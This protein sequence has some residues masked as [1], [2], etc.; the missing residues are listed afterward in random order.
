MFWYV[1]AGIVTVGLLIYAILAANYLFAVIILLGAILGFLAITT[2]FLTLGLY[3]YEVFRV[4]FGRSR[5]IALL[6]SVGVPFL[7][8][9]FGNPNFTQV[10]LITGAVF[11]GL[12]GIL[13]ILALLRARK[14]GDRKPEFT[15]HLP[16]FIFILVALLFAA[17][18][19]TTLYELMVK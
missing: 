18:M 4:D 9:L 15:L 19:A 3:L 8:F 2:S 11:G 5:T 6:A 14:L 10:I 12:D 13:V 16:A 1:V 7:I 17:G